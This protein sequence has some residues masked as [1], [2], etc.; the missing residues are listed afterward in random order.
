MS[1]SNHIEAIAQLSESESIFT[2]AQ[3]RRMGIPRDALHDAVESG[4]IE[5]IVRGAYRMVGSG[6]SFTD[7]LAAIWK[8]T[9]PAKF[10]HERLRASE[11]DGIVVG[12]S[13]ASA[14][15]EMG[16]LHLSPYRLYAPKR[17]NTRNPSAS[18]A[19]RTVPRSDVM[20]S[21][22]LPV[23][24][25][26]RTVFDLVVDDE[27]LSLI[28]DVLKDAWHANRDFDFKRLAGLLRSHYEEARAES[29]YRGL[30]EDSGLRDKEGTP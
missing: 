9:E 25:P 1:N 29:L 5:R 27:D 11:W 20:F 28:A 22:G 21:H 13:T 7:E 19:K 8:L 4:R 14:L 26:E 6:S 10:T 15:L 16:D 24:R 12:G 23:T 30:L 18:F 17:I 2:T 3:A